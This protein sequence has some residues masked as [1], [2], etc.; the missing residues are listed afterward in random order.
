MIRIEP[1]DENSPHMAAV[2]KLGKI[3]RTTLG[4]LPKGGYLDYAR[5][6]RVVVAL[7]DGGNCVGYFLYRIVRDKAV[8]AHFCVAAAARKQGCGR[9]MMCWLIQ[10]TKKQQGIL[11]TCRKDFDEASRTWERLGFHPIGEKPARAKGK[12]LVLWWQGH[13][14]KDLFTAIDEPKAVL[15]VVDSNIFFD[16]MEGTHE[17]SQGLL[18]DWLR[19]FMTVC[20]T[21]ELIIEIE[22]SKDAELVKRRKREVKQFHLLDCSAEAFQTTERLLKPLFPNLVRVQDKSDFRQLVRAAAAQADAFVTRDDNLLARAEEIA[23]CCGLSVMRPGELATQMDTLQRKQ[24]YQRRH[25]A[26]THQVV[27]T[28]IHAVDNKLVD[29]IKQNEEK[30]NA[31]SLPLNRWLAEPHRFHSHQI[32]DN[33]GNILA[34]YVMDRENGVDRVPLLR[35]ADKKRKG[36]LARTTLAGIVRDAVQAGSS[37]VFVTEPHVDGS[38]CM[39]LGF[40]PVEGGFLKLVL[41]GWRTIDEV[42]K[43]IT[44]QDA[45]IDLLKELL[46][47]AKS[48]ASMA[49]DLEHLLWPVKLADAA[50]PSFVVAIKR[51]FAEHLFDVSLAKQSVFGRDVDLALNVESAYYRAA[52]PGVLTAPSR[53]LW[54]VSHCDK[55]QGTMSIRACSRIVEVLKGSPKLLFKRLERLGVFGWKDV[56]TVAKGVDND[57]MAFRFDDTEVMRPISRQ[58][59]LAVLNEHGIKSTF[60]SPVAIPAEAFGRIYSAAF[61]PP[62]VR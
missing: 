58:D 3:N 29:A 14:H 22:R 47:A 2:V 48:D 50:I 35:V 28:R 31:I 54:Y 30:R 9:E 40:L 23:E 15:A 10:A 36:T 59:A 12:V 20:Y 27:R 21:P 41:T 5:E 38:A 49:S 16:L 8:V 33:S 51:Q 26:G 46:E 42:A 52:R 39:D 24:E 60:Q 53:V 57:I 44:W 55:Y 4:F 62:A 13:G 18:A 19:P 45:R 56:Q 6:K 11:L 7:D 37:A 34:V 61:N 1:I 32:T 17:E 43:A 25:V